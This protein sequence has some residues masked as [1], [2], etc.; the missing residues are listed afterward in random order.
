MCLS[1]LFPL[2]Y[3]EE[4]YVLNI[5]SYTRYGRTVCSFACWIVSKATMVS[6]RVCEKSGSSWASS[7]SSEEESV[8]SF[9]FTFS[10]SVVM[11]ERV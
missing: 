7:S 2:P 3:N 1:V 9:A 6:G 5:K 11:I 8:D 4:G 10:V